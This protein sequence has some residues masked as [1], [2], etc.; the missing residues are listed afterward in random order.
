[1]RKKTGGIHYVFATVFGTGFIPFAPG[2]WG[3]LAGLALCMVLHSHLILYLAVFVV[4][5][6]S[7]VFCSGKVEAASG[8][9][10]PSIV[11]IDEF[12]CIFPAF[13]FVRMDLPIIVIGFVLYRVFDILKVPPMRR[14]EGLNGG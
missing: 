3:S 13:L 5:F 14:M 7:G 11:V 1:M 2:T 8:E 6:F 9:K 4:L 10:D 12:A